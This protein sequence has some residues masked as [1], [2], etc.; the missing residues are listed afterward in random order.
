MAMKER[1]KRNSYLAWGLERLRDLFRWPVCLFFNCGRRVGR[2]FGAL[3]TAPAVTDL[4]Q[5]VAWLHAIAVLAF[6]LVGGP[7]LLQVFWRLATRTR[8]LNQQEIEA[9]SDVFGRET[10]H[11]RQ[12]RVAQGGILAPIFRLNNNRAFATWHTINMPLDRQDNIP[13]LV[14]ELTHTLQYEKVGSVYIGQGL[15]VQRQLGAGAY[16]YGG[17][18]G[19]A[20]AY[21]AGKRYSDYNREQQGQ[22][23]QDYCARLRSG[24][25]TRNYESYIEEL[26]KRAV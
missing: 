4:G 23:A 12:V 1:K 24:R 3:S 7:E 11:Y 8:P 5:A 25:D 18:D 14:H 26:R 17:P 19:L 9:A 13:L 6:D 10:I 15:W 20:K 2:L 16:H 22:I 21:A